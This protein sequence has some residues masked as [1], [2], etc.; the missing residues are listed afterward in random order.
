M[1]PSFEPGQVFV[2]SLHQE[3]VKGI[4][5]NFWSKVIQH[6]SASLW[7]PHWTHF[8][9]AC[10]NIEEVRQP[11]ATMLEMTWTDCTGARA[12]SKVSHPFQPWLS[13]GS[14]ARPQVRK[15][16]HLWDDPNHSH[17]LMQPHQ[18]PWARTTQLSHSHIP[19]D[20][21]KI[22]KIVI[23]KPLCFYTTTVT[24]RQDS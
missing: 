8:C 19:D 12:M 21:T 20:D 1:S 24:G 18:G 16:R 2:I 7:S 5:H 4:R 3:N 11:K 17:S 22:I 23:F 9:R 14:L 10:A 13:K 6:E 15:Q